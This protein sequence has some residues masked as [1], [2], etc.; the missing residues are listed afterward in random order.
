MSTIDIA[1]KFPD[2][3]G[4]TLKA[5]TRYAEIGRRGPRDAGRGGFSDSLRDEVVGG[6]WSAQSCPCVMS[7][8]Q[9]GFIPY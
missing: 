3:I 5:A 6:V 9:T 4:H 1:A 7:R 8:Y 2:T